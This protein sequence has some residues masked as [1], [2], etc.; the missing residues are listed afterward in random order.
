MNMKQRKWMSGTL[1]A[2]RQEGM[3]L[4]EVMMGVLVLGVMTVSLY[5][6]F[7]YGF[8]Q[9]RTSRENLRATQI[10]GERMEVIR[11][12]NWDDLNTSGYIPTK[13]V[14]PFYADNPTNLQSNNF[15]YTGAV[16]VAN[17]PF[18]ETYSTNMRMIQIQL[19]W[20]SGRRV[21]TR[22]MTT[23]VAQYGMQKYVY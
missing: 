5:A 17:A 15:F 1:G 12:V 9:I 8:N 6:G 2:R 3:T 4:L 13:F 20:P 23:F 14:A 19:T 22:S 21:S 16:Q 7:A 11:L 10:L 18:T